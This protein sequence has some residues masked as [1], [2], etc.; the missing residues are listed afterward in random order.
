MCAE[1]VADVEYVLVSQAHELF[2]VYVLDRHPLLVH[3]DRF[4]PTLP[5]RTA[6]QYVPCD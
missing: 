3:H 5:P 2:H 4:V 6:R 1:L